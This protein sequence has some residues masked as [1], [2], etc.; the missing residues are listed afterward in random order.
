METHDASVELIYNGRP[1]Q[2]QE[3]DF[4][5]WDKEK[6]SVRILRRTNGNV[7]HV[8]MRIQ[9]HEEVREVLHLKELALEG[10]SAFIMRDVLEVLKRAPNTGLAPAKVSDVRPN[11]WTWHVVSEHTLAFSCQNEATN[12]NFGDRVEFDLQKKFLY[13]T[14]NVEGVRERIS[15]RFNADIEC[16][17]MHAEELCDPAY[18]KEQSMSAIEKRLHEL[19]ALTWSQLTFRD[20]VTENE[21]VSWELAALNQENA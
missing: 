7:S 13:L 18:T 5:E 1:T 16:T 8:Q 6:S 17:H 12:L 4:L 21:V 11:T 3:G 15:V 20:P 2:L 19:V 14:R 9:G 10:L